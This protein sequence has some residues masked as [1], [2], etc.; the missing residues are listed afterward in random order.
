[1]KKIPQ[2][3]NLSDT[4]GPSNELTVYVDFSQL[5]NYW[6]EE[7]GQELDTNL[8]CLSLTESGSDAWD[9]GGYAEYKPINHYPVNMHGSNPPEKGEAQKRPSKLTT[10]VQDASSITIQVPQPDYTLRYS[11][12]FTS[13]SLCFSPCKLLGIFGRR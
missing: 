1:M 7:K 13:I 11:K 6:P 10:A 5:L 12:H 8:S 3:Y 9:G 2:M 4:L